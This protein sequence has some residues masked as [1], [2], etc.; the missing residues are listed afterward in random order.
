LG[1]IEAGLL[2]CP[3]VQ[4]AV[5]LAREDNPGNKQLVA[6]IAGK[7]GSLPEIGVVRDYLKKILPDYM[8]PSA[9]VQLERMP[10]GANG[11]LERR[12]LPAPDFGAQ[13]QRHYVGPRT[14]TEATLAGIWGELLALEKVGVT[15]N[16][17]DLGGHSLLATQLI[18][19]VS[20]AFAVD[21]AVKALFEAG[22]IEKI[23]EQVDLALWVRSRRDLAEDR[24][25]YEDIEL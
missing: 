17:F 25:D 12:A 16:F 9:L 14:P 19:R 24:I 6:Y 22:T 21:L 15:D 5:V 23:A 18:S 13:L 8:V 2:Q 10:L 1:E 11:K 7:A 20:Q 3:G 4:E